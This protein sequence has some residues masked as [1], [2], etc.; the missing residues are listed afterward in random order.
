MRS[1]RIFSGFGSM[2]GKR[3]MIVAGIMVAVM[4]L[5]AALN[6]SSL[7]STPDTLPGQ[8]KLDCS[9]AAARSAGLSAEACRALNESSASASDAREASAGAA[10]PGDEQMSCDA[11]IAELKTLPVSG[12]SPAT[13]AEAQAA[14]EA[15]RKELHQQQ[16]EAAGAMAAGTA[17]TAAASTAAA[18][19]AQGADAALLAGQVAAQSKA[20][21]NAARMQPLRDRATQAT[22]AAVAELHAGMQANPRFGRLIELAGAKGCSGDF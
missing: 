4:S 18:A 13:A 9:S 21:A 7:S 1:L 5:A 19:G 11:I 8:P 16:A 10:R 3:A 2:A 20:A 14:G 15:M 22:A 12:V 17:A 6:A